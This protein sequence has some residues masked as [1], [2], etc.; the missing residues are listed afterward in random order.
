MSTP[1]TDRVKAIKA[2][3]KRAGAL[4]AKRLAGRFQGWLCAFDL[5]RAPGEGRVYRRRFEPV[6]GGRVWWDPKTYT[7]E[8]V[9]ALIRAKAWQ[10]IEG[11]GQD[12]RPTLRPF[13]ALLTP[14]GVLEKQAADL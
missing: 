6:P 10:P 8:A 5:V 3:V 4:R 9:D 1:K 11:E 7:R 12:H 13:A 2:A 14:E